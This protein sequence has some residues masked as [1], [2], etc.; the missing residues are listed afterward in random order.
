MPDD[1]ARRE[2]NQ[3]LYERMITA[4]NGKDRAGFLACLDEAIV[5]E[6]PYYS[7][8]AP[9]AAGKA[10]MGT[11]FT[12]LCERFSSID[13]QLKRF[14]PALDPDLVIA[15]V[16]GSNAVAGTDRVY[17]NDYLFLVGVSHGLITRIFEYSNPNAYARDVNGQ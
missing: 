8:D 2:E 3:R 1:A 11:V 5:F 10:A 13:Y 14:I 16:R 6:A 4:Q 7:P 12:A 17:R 15:E 9:L